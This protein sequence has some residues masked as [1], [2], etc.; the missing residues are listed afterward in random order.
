MWECTASNRR[1]RVRYLDLECAMSPTDTTVYSKCRNLARGIVGWWLKSLEWF[2]SRLD[3][4]EFDSRG[5]DVLRGEMVT[6]L[7]IYRDS[8]QHLICIH[9][10]VCT[11][12]ER[13]TVC[14]KYCYYME[15]PAIYIWSSR[16][17]LKASEQARKPYRSTLNNTQA[18]D[19]RMIS[20]VDPLLAANS[21]RTSMT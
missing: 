4:V 15:D 14:S 16:S 1:G 12:P 13:Q 9:Q 6:V 11:L 3:A 20:N 19:R 2:V 8:R 10:V 5:V 21:C 7:T 17:A 18:L